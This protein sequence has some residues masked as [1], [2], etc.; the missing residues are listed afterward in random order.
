MNTFAG[1]DRRKHE[2]RV[3]SVLVDI[4]VECSL[5]LDKNVARRLYVEHHV[6]STVASRVLFHQTERRLTEFERSRLS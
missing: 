3:L 1:Q 2:N 5:L 4:G 6:P